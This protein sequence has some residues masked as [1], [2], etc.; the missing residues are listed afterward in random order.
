MAEAVGHA[1]AYTGGA[2][3]G[4]KVTWRVTRSTSWQ[5]LEGNAPAW[6]KPSSPSKEIAHG[7]ATTA[8]DGRFRIGF[9]AEADPNVDPQTD[10]VYSYDINVDVT[11]PSGETRSASSVVRGAYTSL[12]ARLATES[13]LEEG[14]PVVFKVHTQTHSDQGCAAVG[15]LRIY[16]LKE[17]RQSPRGIRQNTGGGQGIT[18]DDAIDTT[19]TS[20]WELGKMLLEI[21][22]STG[23]TGMADVSAALPAGIYRAVFTAKDPNGRPAVASCGLQVVNPASDKFPTKLPFFAAVSVTKSEPGQPVS[24]LWGSGYPAARACFEVYKGGSL[25]RREWSAP[26]RTQQLFTFIPDESM[27]GGITVHVI[28]TTMNRLRQF[29]RTIEIPWTNKDLKLRWEHLT[30]KLAPGAKDTWTAVVTD[31]NGHPA[32]ADMLA[33]S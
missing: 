22:V 23:K 18:D 24:L 3:D 20:K 1:L 6:P 31:A 15:V 2:V 25:L 7:D 21:P 30:S 26:G 9:T 27:R 14:K 5:H 33:L 11:E 28:Q 19:N 8:A 13:W 17:P 10:P 16:P 12:K 32:S 29:S 4:A